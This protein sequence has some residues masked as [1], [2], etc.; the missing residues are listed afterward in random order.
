MN[1]G[2]RSAMDQQRDT[3]ADPRDIPAE[4][5]GA[6]AQPRDFDAPSGGTAGE[7]GGIGTRTG[8]TAGEPGGI[9]TRTGA[10]AEPGDPRAQRGTR[11]PP[12]EPAGGQPAPAVGTEAQSG[13]GPANGPMIW[14]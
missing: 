4:S 13:T 11:H 8:G 14:D 10:A 5:R 3:T 6:T 1:T 12:A 9:G 7:P 2:G